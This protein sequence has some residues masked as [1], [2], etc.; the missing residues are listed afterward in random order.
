MTSADKVKE[1]SISG[2]SLLEKTMQHKM[3]HGFL[4]KLITMR[5]SAC[6]AI[7]SNPVTSI[8]LWN[9]GGI[10]LKSDTIAKYDVMSAGPSVK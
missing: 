6:F 2:G 3:Q 4:E 5:F 7:G 1:P 10:P 9:Y 8:F